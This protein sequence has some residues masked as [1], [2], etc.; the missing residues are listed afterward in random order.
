[1]H[2]SF[3]CIAIFPG[4]EELNY[5]EAA[6]KEDS[7]DKDKLDRHIEEAVMKFKLLETDLKVSRLKMALGQ[8]SFAFLTFYPKLVSPLFCAVMVFHFSWIFNLSRF[9]KPLFGVRCLLL[10][11]ENR[12]SKLCFLV[13]TSVFSH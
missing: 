6:E 9:L 8:I 5:S 4:N 7:E 1:V 11:G 12:L 13:T 2:S 10:Q 3:W